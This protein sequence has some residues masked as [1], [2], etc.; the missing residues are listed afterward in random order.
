[1]KRTKSPLFRL[2]ALCLILGCVLP[3]TALA[4]PPQTAMPQSS[5]YLR[6]CSAFVTD[7]GNY[8]FKVTYTIA[9]N[10][11]MD[12]LGAATVIIY[13]SE[14]KTDWF[15]IQ[16]FTYADHPSMVGSNTY[17]YRHSVTFQGKAGKYY[18]ANITAYAVKGSD[19]ER[20]TFY[21]YWP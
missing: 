21:L 4:M 14:D 5:V 17:L 6:P 15:P 13:E 2:L 18:R 7:L 3:V 16:A 11:T 9:A 12:K 8:Q 10:Q 1:M 20:S 19:T